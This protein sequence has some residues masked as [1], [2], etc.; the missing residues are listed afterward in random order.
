MTQTPEG[1]EPPRHIAIIMDG[2]G[3]WAK[4][5]FLPRVAGHKRGL[6]AV[7]EVVTACKEMG[8][9]YLTLF[10]FSTEN[11]RR[12]QEE[13]SFLMDLFL[14]AL[15]HE[16]SKLHSNNIRLQVL[17]SRERFSEELSDRIARA[18]AKTAGNDGLVLTIAADYGGRWDIVN[19]VNELIVE[20]KERVTEA[21]LTEKLAM[22]WA[23]E[24]D[25]FIRTGGEQRIS[26]FLLWQLAYSE[27]YFTDLLWPDFDRAALEQA[28][29]SYWQRERRFGRTSEQLPEH[30]RRDKP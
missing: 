10:A 7:R 26:N 8:V 30:L 22:S 2:N 3:R 21:E 6:D 20:G 14:R 15:E 5:R 24:P 28:L 4:K 11:W 16:V 9:G 29:S 12:P 27:L 18:E 19:A 25:L 1:R 23:P 17:G 13:V